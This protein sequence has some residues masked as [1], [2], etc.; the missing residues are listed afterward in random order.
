MPQ[1]NSSKLSLEDLVAESLN[2]AYESQ[3]LRLMRFDLNQ[4]RVACRLRFVTRPMMT[5]I[6]AILEDQ[7]YIVMRPIDLPA[8]I[9]SESEDVYLMMKRPEMTSASSVMF[10]END[11]DR[12][13][14]RLLGEVELA[15]GKRMKARV[16]RLPAAGDWVKF[17]DQKL[18]MRDGVITHVFR[19]DKSKHT[20]YSVLARHGKAGAV[21]V[22][23]IPA[24]WVQQIG[25]S[26]FEEK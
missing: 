3:H 7:G 10:A 5:K 25:R 15:D 1:N 11:L 17:Q 6:F 22:I 20:H 18:A 14:L 2:H 4:V 21:S 13:E 16:K 19:G 9:A 23:D 8:L 24:A 12:A 26:A